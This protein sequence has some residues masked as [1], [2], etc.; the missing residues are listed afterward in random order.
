MNLS[1]FLVGLATRFVQG[2]LYYGYYYGCRPD[3]TLCI[4]VEVLADS[5][6]RIETFSDSLSL[7]HADNGDKVIDFFP[8]VFYRWRGRQ[9]VLAQQAYGLEYSFH[10]DKSHLINSVREIEFSARRAE[11]YVGVGTRSRSTMSLLF[12]SSTLLRVLG[13]DIH[14]YSHPIAWSDVARYSAQLYSWRLSQGNMY[15]LSYPLES[16]LNYYLHSQR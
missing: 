5:K 4:Q 10:W 16:W 7:A 2:Q 6:M 8:S 13:V 3:F 15:F 14:F 9:I 11:N 12:K 1:L